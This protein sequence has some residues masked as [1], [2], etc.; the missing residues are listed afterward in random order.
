MY[1]AY[2]SGVAWVIGARGGLQFCRH[3]KSWDACCPLYHA[4]FWSYHPHFAAPS[5]CRQGW[6]APLP[7]VLRYWPF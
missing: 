2:F 7:P 3:Q 1:T 6:F 5:D 4:H